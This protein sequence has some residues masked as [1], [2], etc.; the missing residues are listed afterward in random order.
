MQIHQM[1]KTWSRRIRARRLRSYTL[2]IMSN[3]T[4]TGRLMIVREK[5]TMEAVV[6]SCHIITAWPEELLTERTA[7]TL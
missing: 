7:H 1:T 6:V 5:E 4:F 2:Y 3:D